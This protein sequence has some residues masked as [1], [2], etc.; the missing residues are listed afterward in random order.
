MKKDNVCIA[1]GGVVFVGLAYY[2][3]KSKPSS[4]VSRNILSGNTK[5]YSNLMKLSPRYYN[6]TSTEGVPADSAENMSDATVGLTPWTLGH[7]GGNGMEI[8][9]GW[10]ADPDTYSAKVSHSWL[11]EA[12][13]GSHL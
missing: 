12:V 7:N 4:P 11:Q 8:S 10:T 1:L 9:A 5:G 2:L 13:S 3:H 6:S